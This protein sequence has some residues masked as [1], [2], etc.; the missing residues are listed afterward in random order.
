MSMFLFC[1]SILY[2]YAAARTRGATASRNYLYSMAYLPVMMT[3]ESYVR[4]QPW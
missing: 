4:A 3:G 1:F 2:F